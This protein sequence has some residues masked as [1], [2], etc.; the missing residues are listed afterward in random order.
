[1]RSTFLVAGVESGLR[2]IRVSAVFFAL[3]WSLPAVIAALA[4]VLP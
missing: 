3:G 4:E 2:F 1:M